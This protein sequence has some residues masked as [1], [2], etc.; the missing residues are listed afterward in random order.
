MVKRLRRKEEQIEY[1]P[2]E[3]Y[4]QEEEIETMYDGENAMLLDSYFHKEFTG[5]ETEYD[6]GRPMDGKYFE[7][8][9]DSSYK[10]LGTAFGDVWREYWDDADKVDRETLVEVLSWAV[11]DKFLDGMDK[12]YNN[13]AREMARAMLE[14]GSGEVDDIL[15]AY[16]SDEDADHDGLEES[17]AQWFYEAGFVM[18]NGVVRWCGTTRKRRAQ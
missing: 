12:C 16:M 18:W 4:C 8:V 6:D 15:R 10:D 13:L 2:R 5:G 1:T 7:E 17:F 3:M 9:F 14:I 11:L